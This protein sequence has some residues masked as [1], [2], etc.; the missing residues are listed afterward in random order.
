MKIICT[1]KEYYDLQEVI[2][3]GCCWIGQ[4]E[5]KKSKG[6]KKGGLVDLEKFRMASDMMGSKSIKWE[7]LKD[8]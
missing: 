6:N 7:I 2:C 1:E 3:C 4:G 8:D 5:G